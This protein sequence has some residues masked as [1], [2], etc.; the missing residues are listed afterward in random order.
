MSKKEI[1]EG[2]TIDIFAPGGGRKLDTLSV[3]EVIDENVLYGVSE[4]SGIETA[5]Y[6]N[7]GIS[8]QIVAKG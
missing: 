3:K 7:D 1:Y 5:Y 8:I 6:L 2:K 4:V